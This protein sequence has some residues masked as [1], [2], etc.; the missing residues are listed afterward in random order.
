MF[1]PLQSL[2]LTRAADVLKDAEHGLHKLSLSHNFV[3]ELCTY[4]TQENDLMKQIREL[5]DIINALRRETN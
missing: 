2:A 4:D 5:S 3:Q 1:T